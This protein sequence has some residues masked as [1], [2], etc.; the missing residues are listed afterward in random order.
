MSGA[1]IKESHRLKLWGILGEGMGAN[2]VN[3]EKTRSLTKDE[4]VGK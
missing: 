3:K 4:L 2:L 1:V